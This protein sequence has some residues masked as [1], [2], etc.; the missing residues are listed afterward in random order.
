MAKRHQAVLATGITLALLTA[1]AP[2]S[3]KGGEV[4]GPGQQYHL[5]NGWT[6]V[7]HQSVSYGRDDDRVYVGD[8][9]GSGADTL[10]VR[11]GA[12]YHVKNDLSGGGA[13]QVITYGRDGDTVLM[14]DWDGDGVDTP[15][16]RR[17]DSYHLKNS[18]SGGPADAVITYGRADDVVIV[19][20]WDGDGVDTLGV[21][22]GSV[23]HL[24]NVIAGGDADAVVDYGRADDV[25]LV[26]DWDGRRGDTLGVR[27][28]D[29]FLVKNTIAGGD[30]DTVMRY[31]RA[32]DAAL[33]GDWDGNGTDTIGVR[34]TDRRPTEAPVSGMA[35][36]DARMVELINAERA[37]VGV[38]PVRHWPA[39]RDGALRHSTWMAQRQVIQ[40]ADRDTIHADVR[41]A[42]CNPGGEHIVRTFQ[43][44]TTPDPRV[45]MDWYMNSAVHRAGILNPSN[46]HV[47]VGT[48][49][50]GD[51][52]YNTQ[53][54]ARACS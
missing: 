54:F 9:N 2:A 32:A 14:G 50:A 4:E 23:Y 39:L 42:G 37:A 33:V 35:E 51:M 27:R 3:A 18:L 24:K 41:A 48:V 19:G 13:D 25:V 49:E 12:T 8:W 28:G 20:D 43:R 5:T 36:Y 6:G 15:A 29:T 53:R 17:G 47:S 11:R 1:A 22:R 38:A 16:V 44:G 34:S 46:T 7:T 10:A 40:H 26:G 21:R 30:A 45:A 52:I 31:G